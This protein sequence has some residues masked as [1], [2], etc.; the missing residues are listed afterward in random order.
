VRNAQGQFRVIKDAL[1]SGRG[2]REEGD[3]PAAPW[4]MVHAASVVNRGRKDYEGF[5]ACRRWKGGEFTK[6]VAESGECVAY[7]L[8]L[9]VGKDK[10]KV[11]WTG[12]VWL[13]IKAESGESLIGTGERVAK[14]KGFRKKPENGGRWNKEDFDKFRGVPWELY[15]GAGGGFEV[16]SKMRLPADPAEFTATGKGES[17]LTRRRF[18]IRN[19]ELQTLGCAT[20]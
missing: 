18:W 10:F 6:P 8:V 3:H 19:E 7:A 13:G 9:S 16:K 1:E 15:P 20:G 4:M 5:T 17:E 11:R 2:R 12:G 14:A